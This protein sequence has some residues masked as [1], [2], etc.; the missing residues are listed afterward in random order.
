MDDEQAYGD[1]YQWG[2]AA[3]GH[4]KRNSG[5]TGTLSSTDTPGHGDFILAP[6]WP[7]DWRSPQNDNL[8]QGVNGVNNPCPDGYRLPTEAEWEAERENWNSNDRVGAFESPL[9]LTVAGYR[10]RN[11]SIITVGFGGTYWSGTTDGID[12]RPLGFS[13][14]ASMGGADRSN[15]CSVRCI[16]N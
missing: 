6:N 13:S 10:N 3:D 9:K 12:S 15:G 5:I 16:K 1:L 8:W 11:G 14:N 7:Y 4:Q 2:R